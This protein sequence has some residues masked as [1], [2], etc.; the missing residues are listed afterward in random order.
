MA[1]KGN[2]VTVRMGSTESPHRTRQARQPPAASGC[3]RK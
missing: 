2:R 3:L 1:A